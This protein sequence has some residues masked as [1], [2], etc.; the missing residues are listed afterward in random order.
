[1]ARE[2]ERRGKRCNCIR[3]REI[4]GNTLQ[5]ANLELHDLVY[6]TGVSEEH[7][8]SYDTEDDRLAGFLRL[9]LPYENNMLELPDLADAAIIREVHV[10]GQ[11]LGVGTEQAGAA[12]HAGLGKNLIQK[13]EDIARTKGYASLAVIAAVGT[14]EY[15][16][17]RGFDMGELYMVKP[18]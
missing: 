4:R 2:L 14:R 11:S 3:C 17:M 12:Q 16:A 18:L 15:Y 1:V 13:A 7:F 5:K 8:L 9:S 10:Y 6:Q